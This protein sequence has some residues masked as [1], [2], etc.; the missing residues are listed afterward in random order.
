MQLEVQ[1][2]Q[3]AAPRPPTSRGAK[4]PPGGVIPQGGKID[5]IDAIAGFFYD[6][7]GFVYFAY[8]WGKGILKGEEGPDVWQAKILAEI[9]EKSQTLTEA[10]QIAIKSGN[11]TGK[12]AM[13]AWI[14]HW[15]ISTRPF[16]QIVVTANTKTQLDT[17]TWR[18]LAK[19]HNLSIHKDWFEWTATKFYLKA[20]PETWFASAIPWSKDRPEAFAGTHEKYVLFIFDESSL[21]HDKI[22]EVADGSM[23]ENTIWIAVGNPTRNKGR[24]KE[25]F[26]KL[27]HRWRQFTIDARAAKRASKE[28]IKK[29]IEDY[30][31]DSD[32]CR[33]KVKGIFP[34]A[35]TTQFISEEVVEEARK[36][37]LEPSVFNHMPTIMAVDPARFGDDETVFALRQGLYLYP[38]EGG[39]EMAAFRG[40]DTMQT[41]GLA[42][43]WINKYH[44]VAV[45]IDEIGIGAGV[46]DR[47]HQLD[48]KE[49][50]GVNV[51]KAAIEENEYF[52]L[53]AEIW[54][55]AREWL[56]NGSIPDDQVLTDDLTGPDYGF[57]SR[58]R[59]KL[60]SKDDMKAR[61]LASPGRG[62][63][64]ALTFA[65]PVAIQTSER[66]KAD[67]A[68]TERVDIRGTA[69]ADRR[70]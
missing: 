13:I 34:R 10:L 43:E 53:R 47:L 16:P 70:V 6:P 30:G 22:W 44:P 21:I 19:W 9:G 36:R 15:F 46:V 38:K 28:R 51:S 7:L 8:P 49:V 4:A 56:K 52:N 12:T 41:A 37:K 27:R 11:E 66:R 42:A 50:I 26:N 60:E 17:K 55:K 2:A 18:E 67:R 35:A 1:S 31:E 39:Q 5:L 61:G 25:C 58:N 29:W 23:S 65:M 62:D 32:Y 45:F 69:G 59:V 20:H 64:L 48:Y 40:K 3:K 33:V 68:E 24:F 14:V 63:A 57:D 54:G